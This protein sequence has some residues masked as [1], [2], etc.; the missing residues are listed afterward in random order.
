MAVRVAVRVR[1]P[2]TRGGVYRPVCQLLQGTVKQMTNKSIKMD[3]QWHFNLK[4]IEKQTNMSDQLHE[5]QLYY[6]LTQ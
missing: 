5:T 4:I 3:D 6:T 2:A 1:V